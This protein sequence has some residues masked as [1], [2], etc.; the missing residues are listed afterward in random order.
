MALTT[1]EIAQQ[2]GLTP[3]RIYQMIWDGE[4]AAK[5]H[6]RDYLIED[7][8]IEIINRRRDLRRKFENQP[9]EKSVN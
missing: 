5:K 1:K 3:G 6:G 9:K 4:I 7:S 2:V 8:Q